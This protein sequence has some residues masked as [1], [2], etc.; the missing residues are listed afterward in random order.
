MNNISKILKNYICEHEL[1]IVVNSEIKKRLASIARK[2]N[3]SI[4]GLI[5]YILQ[6]Y[7]NRVKEIYCFGPEDGNKYE[8]IDGD[9]RFHIYLSKQDYR[10]LKKMHADLNFF[11]MGALLRRIIL[12]FLEEYEKLGITRVEMKCS[13]ITLK[14]FLKLTRIK[15]WNKRR[16]LS[17]FSGNTTPFYKAIY[18]DCYQVIGFETYY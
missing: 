7:N 16:E 12:F 18:N 1:H 4:S 11:S 6:I 8:R 5:V 13:V 3:I 2:F 14:L 17:H 15:K 9:A 10:F